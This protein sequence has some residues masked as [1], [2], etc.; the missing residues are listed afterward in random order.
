MSK[1][2]DEKNYLWGFVHIMRGLPGSGKSTF[3]KNK[4]SNGEWP[5]AVI[6]S[7]DDYFVNPRTKEYKY[8]P[9]KITEAHIQ[10]R[11]KFFKTLIHRNCPEHVVVDNTNI[12]LSHMAEYILIAKTMNF[13]ITIHSLRGS[14]LTDRQLAARCVHNVPVDQITKMRRMWQQTD[15]S[16]A[17]AR[18][19]DSDDYT[20]DFDGEYDLHEY[21]LEV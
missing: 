17:I 2:K 21:E 10:C 18:F 5:G 1:N 15:D 14:R 13:N 4:I 9:R 8:D 12:R 11:V 20:I 19:L 7:A 3:C 16:A 6:C